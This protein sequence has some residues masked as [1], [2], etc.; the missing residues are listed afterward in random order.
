[1]LPP[2]AAG[3]LLAA[4]CVLRAACCWLRL[5]A[6]TL[7]VPA[8]HQAMTALTSNHDVGSHNYFLLHG[9]DVAPW[10]ILPYATDKVSKLTFS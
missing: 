7:H 3:L 2:P 5:S 9:R 4:G 1:M 6:P 8:R 10:R